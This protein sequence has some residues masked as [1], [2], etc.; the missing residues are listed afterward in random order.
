MKKLNAKLVPAMALAMIAGSLMLPMAGC[1]HHHHGPPPP[2][3][4]P[5][6]DHPDHPNHPP[7]H[8]GPGR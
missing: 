6:P 8:P 2:D 1:G 5:H 4:G 7:D 3:A